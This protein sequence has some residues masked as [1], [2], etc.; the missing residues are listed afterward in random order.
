MTT[1]AGILRRGGGVRDTPSGHADDDR[2]AASR[3][4]VVMAAYNTQRWIGE[5]LATLQA[6]TV[7]AWDCVVIDD[8][9]TDATRSIVADI[10]A[11]DPRIVL[12]A[13]HHVGV[14]A[15]R[16]RGLSHLGDSVGIVMFL[17]S[18]DLLLPDALDTLTQHLAIR[19]DAVG[20]FGLAEYVNSDGD[21]VRPGQHP[22]LQRA[23]RKVRGFRFR[24][25][26]A[27]EDS[28]FGDIAVYGPI[29]PSAVGLHRRS[30]L[31]AV[32]GCDP[33]LRLLSDWDLYIRMSRRGPFAMVDRQVAW[34]RRH[35]ANLTKDPVENAAGHAVVVQRAW[36]DADNTPA[37]RRLIAR[38]LWLTR[39][40][41][42]PML[43]RTVLGA[44]RRGD[45]RHAARATKALIGHASTL[46]LIK[47]R[48]ATLRTIQRTLEAPATTTPTNSRGHA[49]AGL[50]TDAIR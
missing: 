50:D 32:G 9:S 38:A 10:A 37:Q 28:T 19:P 36:L 4:G 46:T 14:A 3:V 35:D 42:T 5:S 48:R 7:A 30:V 20:V 44:I 2:A 15:A 27:G 47:L 21:P 1:N 41:D 13:H 26:L 33:E 11:T 6:Q 8:G 31:E 39:A 23:R 22:E 34:Y 49:E 40:A 24:P 18:D 12:V 43:T 25:L 17:D 45:L 29:W 16:N